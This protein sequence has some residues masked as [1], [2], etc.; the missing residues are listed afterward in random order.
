MM[1]TENGITTTD[2]RVR[3]HYLAAALAVVDR[4]RREGVPLL[5]YIHWSLLDNF[6]WGSG[7]KPRFGLYAVDRTTF[8]R[9]AKPSAAAYRAMVAARRS[10]A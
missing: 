1:I 9:T 6:E 8:H 4:M 5:G 3:V 2:D 10:R 7:Y